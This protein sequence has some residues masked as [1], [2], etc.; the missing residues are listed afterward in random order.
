MVIVQ[1]QR[2]H[3]L[4]GRFQNQ[5]SFQ[6]ASVKAGFMMIKGCGGVEK[7]LTHF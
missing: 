6:G 2:Y 4:N 1:R 3:L 5:L 7:V